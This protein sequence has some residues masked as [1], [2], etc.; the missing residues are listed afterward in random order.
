MWIISSNAHDSLI[1]YNFYH[2]YVTEE[3]IETGC[4]GR[5]EDTVKE[6][7]ERTREATAPAGFSHQ[8]YGSC[9]FSGAVISV[10]EQELKGVQP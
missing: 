4:V 10:K 5:R 8:H 3:E 1:W 6:Q 7:V 2:S 9:H